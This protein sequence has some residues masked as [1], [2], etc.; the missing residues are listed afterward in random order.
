MH[1]TYTLR[2]NCATCYLKGELDHHNAQQAR[3]ELDALLRDPAVR[4]LH[5]DLCELQFMDSS[6]IGMI[7]G[8]YKKIRDRG[9]R[10]VLLHTQPAVDRVLELSGI[11]QLMEKEG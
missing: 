2:G 11:Y 10:M 6:G 1:I 4:H 8:R 9:G 3:R 7:L 5:L